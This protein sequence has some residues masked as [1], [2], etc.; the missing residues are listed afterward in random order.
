MTQSMAA[1]IVGGILPAVFFGVSGALAKSSTQ[2]GIG[3]GLYIL[4]IGAAVAL[5]GCV[6][7][8][9]IPDRTINMRSGLFASLVGI[10]WAFAAGF[11][12]ISLA[13]YGVPVSKLAPIYNMNTLVTVVIG[14][15]VFAELTDV[16]AWKL[17]SGA[18]LIVAGGMLVANS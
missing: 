18:L 6:F 5:V 16:N 15:F 1:I 13:R 14:L 4:C 7:C 17:V 12:A 2:A 8:L 3:T 10:T 9:F 11:V